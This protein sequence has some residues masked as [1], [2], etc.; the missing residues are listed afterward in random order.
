MDSVSSWWQSQ[1]ARRVANLYSFSRA[2][3]VGVGEATGGGSLL[4]SLVFA[5][6]LLGECASECVIMRHDFST[7]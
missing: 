6:L 3:K 1:W 4:I 2:V 7:R 5:A